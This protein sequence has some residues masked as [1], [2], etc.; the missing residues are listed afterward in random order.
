MT[1]IIIGLLEMKSIWHV[2]GS[3]CKCLVGC[4]SA[5]CGHWSVKRVMCDGQ[6]ANHSV[7]NVYSV[8]AAEHNVVTISVKCDVQSPIHN[9][10]SGH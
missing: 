2:L 3:E 8:W 5:Q 7:V 6:S 9:V 1:K 10:Y 4:Y